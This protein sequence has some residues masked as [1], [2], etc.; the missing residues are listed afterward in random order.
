MG[1][2]KNHRKRSC[3]DPFRG[4]FLI[5]AMVKVSFTIVAGDL[6][7]YSVYG[8]WDGDPLASMGAGGRGGCGKGTKHA[9]AYMP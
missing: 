5:P 9:Q 2:S 8:A 6:A 7:N 1:L 3:L 4:H